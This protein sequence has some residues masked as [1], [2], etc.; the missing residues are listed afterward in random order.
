MEVHTHGLSGGKKCTHST[1]IKA[2]FTFVKVPL[3]LLHSSPPPSSKSRLGDLLPI[4]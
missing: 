4:S 2:D 1:R 3:P